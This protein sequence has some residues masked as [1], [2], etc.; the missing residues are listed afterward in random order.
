MRI[1]LDCCC[2]NRPFDDQSQS[3]IRDEADAILSILARYAQSGHTIL[4][5]AV[6]RLELSRIP[7]ADKRIKAHM[8][9]AAASH[10]VPA[11][12]QVLLKAE[13]IQRTANIRKMDALHLAS[14][15]AGRA[16]IFLTTDM[17]LLRN[18]GKLRLA[19]RAMNP[20]SHLAEIIENDEY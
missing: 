14:A 4:G 20:V 11:S 10:E 13:K 5:S 6:L 8:L 9:Y 12:E 16:D 15:E 3:R 18:C 7:D 1:Y 19:L 17:S 2:F